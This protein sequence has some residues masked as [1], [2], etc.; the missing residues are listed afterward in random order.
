[1]NIRIAQIIVA[2]G[3]KRTEFAKKIGI[4]SPFVS[5]LCSGAKKASDRTITD[6][7]REFNVSETWLRTGEGEMFV[8]KEP[9]PLDKLLFELLGGEAVTDE[10]RVLVKNF[11]ELPDASRKAVIEFVQKC[12]GEL[13]APAAISKTETTT[14][15][16]DTAGQER[17]GLDLAAELAELKRQNQEM[18]R[19]NQEL[20]AEIAAMKEEER[21]EE[22]AADFREAFSALQS[23]LAGNSDPAKRAKK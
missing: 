15:A 13:S 16:P 1:M 14:P 18:I 23:G 11:L 3:I 17:T 20:A 9:Q 7:C 2:L 10:D 12:A 6:I 21:D 22:L 19:Q 8:K 4:S 5:E